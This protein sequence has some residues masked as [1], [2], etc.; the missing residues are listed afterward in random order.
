MLHRA[1]TRGSRAP[2]GKESALTAAVTTTGVAGPSRRALANSATQSTEQTRSSGR[3]GAQRGQ[4]DVSAARPSGWSLAIGG[5]S[6]WRRRSRCRGKRPR[7]GPQASW[8]AAAHVSMEVIGMACRS[9]ARAGRLCVGV[10]L[11]R[12]R[13]SRDRLGFADAG[14]DRHPARLAFLGRGRLLLRCR[15][16]L[17]LEVVMGALDRRL[18][19]LAVQRAVDDD[20]PPRSVELDQH[21]GG[22]GFGR[23]RRR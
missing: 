3:P 13:G 15:G 20:R 9:G 14:G 2:S 12:C 21:A 5:A 11:G 22:P 8:S 1:R 4:S 18:D 23:R 19:E 7:T 10:V 16:S 6:R 17:R